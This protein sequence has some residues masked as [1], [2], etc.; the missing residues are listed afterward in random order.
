[1]PPPSTKPPKTKT[2]PWALPPDSSTIKA[3]V[4]KAANLQLQ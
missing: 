4:V 1:M 2:M 3:A